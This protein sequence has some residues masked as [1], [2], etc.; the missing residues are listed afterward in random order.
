M[1]VPTLA[2][3][4]KSVVVQATAWRVVAFYGRDR[5]YFKRVTRTVAHARNVARAAGPAGRGPGP[6]RGWRLPRPGVDRG[7]EGLRL[8]C[9]MLLALNREPDSTNAWLEMQDSRYTP[10]RNVGSELV[11]GLYFDRLSTFFSDLPPDLVPTPDL[12]GMGG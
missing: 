6:R 4:E 9:D 1:P 5:G 3:Y 8:A 10:Y 7:G 2:E 11:P 12:G